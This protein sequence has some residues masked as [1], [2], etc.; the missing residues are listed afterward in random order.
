MPN[1]SA[2]L[3]I[4]AHS[5]IDTVYQ[6]GN[7]N[8]L[9]DFGE[10]VRLDFTVT[11]SGQASSGTVQ[12]LSL[13]SIP[14]GNVTIYPSPVPVLQ[15]VNAGDSVHPYPPFKVK[16]STSVNDT[17][18]PQKFILSTTL[19]TGI[20]RDTT[21]VL[22]FGPK[23]AL[24]SVRFEEPINNHIDPGDTIR[25]YLTLR[26][27]GC[28]QANRLQGKLT[29][30]SGNATV[31][32]DGLN[33]G[34]IPPYSF[35]EDSLSYFRVKITGTSVL[36]FNYE[37]SPANSLGRIWNF[38]FNLT[39]PTQ[40]VTSAGFESTD[41]RIKF[42]WTPP[43]SPVRGYNIYRSREADGV[44]SRLNDRIIEG[45]SLYNDYPLPANT[46]Y[47]YKIACVSSFGVEGALSE[48]FKAWTTIPYRPGWPV[49]N[50]DLALGNRTQGS[51][52][53]EDV[54]HNIRKEIFLTI[55]DDIDACKG[56]MLAFKEDGKEF[57]NFD[58]N[59]T[60]EGGFYKFVKASSSSTPAI[61]DVDQDGKPDIVVTTRENQDTGFY[62]DRGMVFAISAV[63]LD[64]GFVPHRLWKANITSDYKGG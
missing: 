63:D 30:I 41:N 39:P 20:Q 27:S 55:G 29:L 37:L 9:A 38:T 52:M 18:V 48:P 40:V 23:I 12:S 49:T 6:Y 16:V 62:S 47:Y 33:V 58:G 10:T 45:Y 7:S 42:H 53:T 46:I 24:Y 44:Y 17:L 43:G 28:G 54:D 8:G 13:T 15:T 1:D 31:L 57:I 35:R 22:L 50:I 19:T 25:L 32:D 21:T 34:D 3:H 5:V 59:P 2:K 56:G 64:S 61:C 4:A 51:P 60:Y 26:N 11:N 36:K 14:A